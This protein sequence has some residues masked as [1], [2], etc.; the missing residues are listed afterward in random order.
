MGFRQKH[1]MYFV[2]NGAVDSGPPNE[3][4]ISVSGIKR[5]IDA[6]KDTGA[7]MRV[8]GAAPRETRLLSKMLV[9]L[10]H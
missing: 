10:S 9:L 6:R 5:K 3:T 8:Q 2:V 7:A 4:S 1:K